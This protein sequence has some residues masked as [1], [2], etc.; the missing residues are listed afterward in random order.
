MHQY[1]ITSA[2]FISPGE[3]GDPDAVL[4]TDDLEILKQQAGL[5]FGYRI[6]QQQQQQQQA[7]PTPLRERKYDNVKKS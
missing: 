5:S 7:T 4:A 6:L 3:S 2:D 1:K